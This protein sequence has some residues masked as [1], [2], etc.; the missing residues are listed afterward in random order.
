MK[1]ALRYIAARMDENEVVLLANLFLIETAIN[2]YV[3]QDGKHK[4]FESETDLMYPPD[5]MRFVDFLEKTV[6]SLSDI[7]QIFV[8][9]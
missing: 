6:R 9:P 7:W 5:W 3:D 4:V 1:P 8:R 2:T